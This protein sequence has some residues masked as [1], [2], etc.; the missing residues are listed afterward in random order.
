MELPKRRSRNQRRHSLLLLNPRHIHPARHLVPHPQ[1]RPRT[2]LRP[3]R[4]QSLHSRL[5]LG[6][7]LP[8]RRNTHRGNAL[9]LLH[10]HPHPRLL[11]RHLKKILLAGHA[12]TSTN[13]HLH[14][15]LHSLSPD[16]THQRRHVFDGRVLQRR[17]DSCQFGLT[18]VCEYHLRRANYHFFE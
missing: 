15:N 7:R 1:H 3:T 14:Q 10:L 4:R 16:R 9:P 12:S 2:N 8:L 13:A 6:R 18:R 5:S 17:N 11:G